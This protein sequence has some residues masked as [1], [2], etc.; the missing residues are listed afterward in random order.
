MT[1]IFQVDGI[2]VQIL[3]FYFEFDNLIVTLILSGDIREIGFETFGFKGIVNQF[4]V[5]FIDL[6]FLGNSFCFFCQYRT[7]I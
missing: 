4:T 5:P 7:F 1:L 6:L 2:L 3:L